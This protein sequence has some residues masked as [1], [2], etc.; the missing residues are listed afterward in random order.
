MIQLTLT[1]RQFDYLQQAVANDIDDLEDFAGCGFPVDM[2]EAKE[3]QAL[4]SKVE[5]EQLL[6]F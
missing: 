2:R 3:V 1:N 4:L 6:P 5:Q